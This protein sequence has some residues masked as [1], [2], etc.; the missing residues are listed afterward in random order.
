MAAQ[1]LV[2][3]GPPCSGKSTLAGLI[4]SE[5]GIRRLQVDRILSALIP[6]SA[7][8]KSDRDLA[9]R[10]MH[11]L[12][13]ELLDCGHAVS[14]DATYSTRLHRAAIETL[15]TNLSA[16][17]YLI[18]CHVSPVAAVARFKGRQDHPAI[19]LN[20]ERVRDL[21]RRYPF[22]N[23]GLT[24]TEDMAPAAAL[25]CI[26]HYMR[27]ARTLNIDGRWSAAATAS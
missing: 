24:I 7:R 11:L 14:L 22:S 6:N 26:E 27:N 15:F 13:K 8:G 23:L 12:A 10:T 2:V 16:P 17:I 19:D 1:L 3:A 20:E 18:E 25:K 4:G 5:L 9:Y 21:A